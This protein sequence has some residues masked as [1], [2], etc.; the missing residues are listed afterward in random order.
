MNRCFDIGIDTRFCPCDVCSRTR[1]LS[2]AARVE[3]SLDSGQRGHDARASGLFL[4]THANLNSRG[5]QAD[6]V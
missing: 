5:A 6:H 3:R 4:S 2:A 1:A